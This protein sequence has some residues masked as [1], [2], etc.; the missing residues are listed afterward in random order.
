MRM[1]PRH[2]RVRAGRTP[3]AV[4]LFLVGFATLIVFVSFYYL[5]PAMK[6]ALSAGPSQRRHL[7][8]HSSLL[9]ALILLILFVGLL[10]T[11]RIGRFFFPRSTP[12][13][14]KT[15]YVDA[16]AESAKRISVPDRSD[17]D[18]DQPQNRPT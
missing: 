7:A 13:P 14:A 11:F 10:M 18:D 4:L 3:W 6:A 16:W 1:L 8:A 9:M 17:E 5:M 2:R 12:P 15:K